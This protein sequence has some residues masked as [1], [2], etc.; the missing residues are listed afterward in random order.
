M[1]F[2][3][4]IIGCEKSQTGINNHK[5]SIGMSTV[6]DIKANALH[7]NSAADCMSKMPNKQ[8]KSILPAFD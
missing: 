2:D 4:W 3:H 5:I 8:D 6:I 7:T 1:F